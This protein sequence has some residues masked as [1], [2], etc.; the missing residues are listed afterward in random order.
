MAS[1]VLDN[2][3]F[4]EANF[5]SLVKKYPHQS[6]IICH[7]EVFAGDDALEKARMKY[8]KSIPLFFPVPG[9]EEFNHLL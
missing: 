6:I 3:A 9:A 5:E 1:K 8:P 7:G 2:D 4:V